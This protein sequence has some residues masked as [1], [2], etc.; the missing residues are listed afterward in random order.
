MDVLIL[1]NQ[2]LFKN[3]QN[4]LENNENWEQIFELD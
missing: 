3:Q 2:I 1:Q 4:N